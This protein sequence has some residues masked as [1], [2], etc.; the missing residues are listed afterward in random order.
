[1]IISLRNAIHNTNAK[2]V[3]NLAVPQEKRHMRMKLD[4][5]NIRLRDL[6]ETGFDWD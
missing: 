3:I 2:Q 1:M 5:D 6:V 4:T